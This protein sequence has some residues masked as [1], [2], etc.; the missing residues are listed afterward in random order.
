MVGAVFDVMFDSVH[1]CDSPTLNSTRSTDRRGTGHPP[2]VAGSWRAWSAPR[3]TAAT[4][5]A[6]RSATSG[7]AAA[8]APNELATIDPRASTT[9]HASTTA[10]A[11]TR[12]RVRGYDGAPYP[13]CG[14]GAV[15]CT[16][17]CLAAM[18]G[19]VTPVESGLSESLRR[20]RCDPAAAE[21]S[22]A[23]ALASPRSIVAATA[24]S[25]WTTAR[26]LL[27]APIVRAISVAS[28]GWPGHRGRSCGPARV[29]VTAGM[30]VSKRS[31]ATCSSVSVSS[32]RATDKLPR[33]A[34]LRSRS[35]GAPGDSDT[36]V[37]YTYPSAV[38]AGTATHCPAS[39]P[40]AP[41]A[42]P[43]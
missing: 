18:R 22:A 23:A 26:G 38:S 17:S 4:K 13:G 28:A 37:P 2:A 29:E 33:N 39:R 25:P 11:S 14:R 36:R 40:V 3:L 10:C 34:T 1:S 27:A 21:P 41:V 9:Y 15:P 35:R 20:T 5:S 12:D 43:G 8:A 30:V 31:R 32:A 24:L 19:M 7:S 16:V 42:P 6:Y